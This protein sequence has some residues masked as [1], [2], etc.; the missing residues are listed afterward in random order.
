MNSIFRN[1]LTNGGLFFDLFENATSNMVE[2]AKLLVTVINSNIDG[3]RELFVEQL[4]RMENNSDNITHKIYLNIN[5]IIFTPLN[6]SNIR[7]LAAG[8]HDVAD[9]I[10]EAGGRMH[11]YN[12]VDFNPAMAEISAILLKTAIEI[13]KA[14][15]LL[16]T[17]K[18][19]EPVFELCRQIKIYERQSDLVYYNSIANLFANEKDAIQLVKYREILHSLETSVNKCKNVT[20]VLNTILLNR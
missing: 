15:N 1:Y 13:E 20:D 5:K 16:R 3:T 4:G 12:I 19:S 6:R 14:V 2:M 11:L 18:K 9:T 8:I 7:Q 17:S 10:Q